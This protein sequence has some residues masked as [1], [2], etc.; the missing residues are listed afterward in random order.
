LLDLV[1]LWQRLAVITQPMRPRRGDAAS[2]NPFM[3]CSL[4]FVFWAALVALYWASCVVA[5]VAQDLLDFQS[6]RL[7]AFWGVR[8]TRR[9]ALL[10][11]SLL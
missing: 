7:V 1:L 3:L 8:L 4:R 10:L 11:S 9:R 5:N 2:A 6:K